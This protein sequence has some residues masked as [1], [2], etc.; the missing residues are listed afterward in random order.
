M[1]FPTHVGV[2]LPLPSAISLPMSLP[3]ARGGVSRKR[4]PFAPRISSSPR[5]WG[6][7]LPRH[8]KPSRSAV[9]PTHVGV[10]LTVVDDRLRA[11]GLPHARGGVS[12]HRSHGLS[13]SASSPRTWGCFR[14]AD[15]YL[16]PFSVFPTHV[17]VFLFSS[18]VSRLSSCLPHAR[19]GV[20]SLLILAAFGGQSSPRTWGCFSWDMYTQPL[21]LV[22]PT[23][24]GV[25]P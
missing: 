3:H 13:V 22:F 24:V 21:W 18:V 4:L 12:S 11:L 19:G 25:F 17:G 1:V 14:L 2:F 15:H 5:T 10:F 23:H 16:R 7:F 6:C 9:F 20:S 8:A